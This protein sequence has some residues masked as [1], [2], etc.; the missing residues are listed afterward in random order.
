MK[1]SICTADFVARE[2]NYNVRPWDWGRADAITR[3]AFHASDTAFAAKFDELTG[4][5]RDIGFENME[6]WVAQFDPWRASPTMLQSAQDILKRLGM[7]VVGTTAGLRQ[8]SISDNDGSVTM[9]ANKALGAGFIAVGLH[10]SNDATAARLCRQYGLRYAIENHP[11]KTAEEAR[12]RL[13]A[14]AGNFDG[15]PEGSRRPGWVGA[16]IDTGWY[17]TQGYDPV[18][19]V[20]VLKDHLLHVHLKDVKAAGMPHE[21]CALGEG[22]VDDHGVLAALQQIGYDGYVSIEHEPEYHDP[23]K[24]LRASLQRVKAWL[25]RQ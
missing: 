24:D 7:R 20:H 4:I 10:P 13:E 22:I 11:E 8:P 25:A 23:V 18:Q 5:C 9:K 15:L 1:I 16:C 12:D 19:A 3:D 2:A 6:L 17:A 14:I 21:T